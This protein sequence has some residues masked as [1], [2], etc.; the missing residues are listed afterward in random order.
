VVA[1]AS[2][3]WLISND[4]CAFSFLCADM[5]GTEIESDLALIYRV[6]NAHRHP[7]AIFFD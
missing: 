7:D 4:E 1:I 5:A 2:A 6:I 3:V